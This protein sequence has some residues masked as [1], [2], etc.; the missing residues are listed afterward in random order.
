VEQ[1]DS[2][3]L[4]LGFLPAVTVTLTSQ[5]TWVQ[6]VMA[7][8]GGVAVMA[9]D[10]AFAD[11][12]RP[13]DSELVYARGAAYGTAVGSARRGIVGLNVE[14]VT[15][16]LTQADKVQALLGAPGNELP[17]VLCVR[18]GL[19]ELSARI[20]HTMFLHTPSI[21]EVGVTVRFGGE[22]VVHQMAGSEA[23]P[24]AKKLGTPLL[25]LADIDAFYAT[26]GDID[27]DNLTLGD[28]DRRWDLAGYANV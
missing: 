13:Y 14:L 6:N 9:T 24:P 28:I 15:D 12:D 20:P 18:K 22:M 3:G 27:A 26:L 5:E 16:T 17:P 7:P 21:N 25:T 2:A 11:I 10:K 4:S 1:F 23:K 19:N 8:R